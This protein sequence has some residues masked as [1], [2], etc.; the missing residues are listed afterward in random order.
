ML[1]VLEYFFPQLV[2]LIKQDLVLPLQFIVVSLAAL[3]TQV[4]LDLV[5]E[6]L[7][8]ILGH[9]QLLLHDL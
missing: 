3:P 9:L 2:P 1:L 8:Q 6:V 7:V 5:C 4:V